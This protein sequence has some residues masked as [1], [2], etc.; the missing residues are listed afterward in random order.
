MCV[1]KFCV[2]G[3]LI[4]RVLDTRISS[5]NIV[6][7]RNSGAD[8]VQIVMPSGEV[9]LSVIAAEKLDFFKVPCG[10][11]GGHHQAKDTD[12]NGCSEDISLLISS[13]RQALGNA[14]FGVENS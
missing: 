10:A 13:D 5:D 4:L 3:D 6:D 12:C 14:G 8:P 11:E 1:K 9:Q 7:A 2:I